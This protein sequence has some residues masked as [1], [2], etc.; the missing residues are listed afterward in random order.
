MMRVLLVCLLLIEPL[1]AEPPAADP[2]A[3]DVA[4]IET[5]VRKA[6]PPIGGTFFVGS[7]SIRMWKTL[8]AD[9][10]G[11][12]VLN[13]GFGGSELSDVVQ[14]ANRIV[15]PDGKPTSCGRMNTYDVSAPK[16]PTL[17]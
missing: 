16:M 15:V 10:P 1:H 5:R 12:P 6:A 14:F 3:T 2:W 7:S 9:F 11:L 13:R 8:Q 17:L 4:G